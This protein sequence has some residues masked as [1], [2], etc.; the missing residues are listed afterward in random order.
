MRVEPGH[1]QKLPLEAADTGS[2]VVQMYWS[3]FDIYYDLF[4]AKAA[5]SQAAR[6]ALEK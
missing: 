5:D 3:N 1:H 2:H 4:Q 6:W